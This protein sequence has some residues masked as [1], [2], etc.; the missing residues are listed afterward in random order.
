MAQLL[1]DGIADLG[2]EHDDADPPV[3]VTGARRIRL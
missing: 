3:T 2:R 1:Y